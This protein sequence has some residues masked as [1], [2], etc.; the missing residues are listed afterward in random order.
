HP[1]PAPLR[2]AATQPTS[3]PGQ[4][5]IGS[6]TTVS[7]TPQ[8]ITLTG[9]Q[10][11]LTDTGTI[12]GP[13]AGLL[14]ISGNNASRVLRLDAGAALSG[15]TLTGGRATDGLGGGGLLNYGSSW[16]PTGSDSNNS[17]AGVRGGGRLEAG[18]ARR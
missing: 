4:D 15:L 17:A 1:I 5:C 8:T 9:G 11:T 6:D 7:T 12:T 16:L 3:T 2:Q 13:G 18:R 14:S 10:L